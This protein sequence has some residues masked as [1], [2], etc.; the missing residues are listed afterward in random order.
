[1]IGTTQ[2]A[3]G[4]HSASL[5]DEMS[6]LEIELLN[7]SMLLANRDTHPL[8]SDAPVFHVDGEFIRVG[9]VAA[10]GANQYR[11]SRFARAC[12]SDQLS[13]PVHAAGSPIVW[14]DA[15]SARII[16][17]T[18]YHIGQT[19][20]VE[21]QGLGD[22]NPVAGTA[23]ANGRAITPLMPVHGW[24]RRQTNGDIHLNWVRRSRLDLGWVDG[25]DQLMVEDREAYHVLIFADDNIVGDW[26]V[27][28][29]ALHI[30]ADDYA[31]LG[32]PSDVEVRFSVQQIGRFTQSMPLLFAL[33]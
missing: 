2:N 30:S 18:A 21:A 15:A 6:S 14:M 19:V 23:V 9:R 5:I 31:C 4:S 26:T 24:A 22:L 25:V 20:T 7:G 12:F 16:A 27:L 13:A 17:A 8:A 28:E 32:I 3:L 11:F 1:V 29:S 33:A 10:L